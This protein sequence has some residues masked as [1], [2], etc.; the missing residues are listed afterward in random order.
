[1]LNRYFPSPYYPDSLPDSLAT[2]RFTVANDSI[3]RRYTC[4]SDSANFPSDFL[5]VHPVSG[6]SVHFETIV[7]HA[8]ADSVFA[9][10]AGSIRFVP[11]RTV[12]T[13]LAFSFNDTAI[14]C[15]DEL[16]KD[17][18]DNPYYNKTVMR[19]N[20]SI[21]EY[22][23]P[24]RF[25]STYVKTMDHSM[26]VIGDSIFVKAFNGRADLHYFEESEII[27]AP[28]S[29]VRIQCDCWTCETIY[30]KIGIPRDRKYK[31]KFVGETAAVGEK[32]LL[33]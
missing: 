20:D 8:D 17:G 11:D 21:I 33:Q 1:M 9:L 26:E 31:I 23:T 2:L 10:I 27:A 19:V 14:N 28:P 15:C 25:H 13:I 22:W 6:N 7:G 4:N 32:I 24:Q 18:T 29:E 12:P 16:L 3:L 5:A 30:F